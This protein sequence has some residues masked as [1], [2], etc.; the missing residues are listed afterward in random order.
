M[1]RL[2]FFLIFLLLTASP[3]LVKNA[4]GYYITLEGNTIKVQF[5]ITHLGKRLKPSIDLAQNGRA[6]YFDAEE[7][8]QYLSPAEVLEIGATYKGHSMRKL[9]RQHP[10]ISIFNSMTQYN[11]GYILMFKWMDW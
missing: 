2:L 7:R 4:P 6:L 9:A 1:Y 10:N 5:S 11:Y 3:A 8:M